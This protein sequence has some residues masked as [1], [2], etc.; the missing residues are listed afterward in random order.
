MLIILNLILF[1]TLQRY[2]ISSL[3]A[4][5]SVMLRLNVEGLVMNDVT[6]LILMY[7]IIPLWFTAGIVDW[8]AT[9]AVHCCTAGP[10]ESLIHLLMFIEVEFLFYGSP[11]R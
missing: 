1:S 7:F 3:Q 2:L 9:A 10:K 11:L 6:Q 4:I 8:F 5:T